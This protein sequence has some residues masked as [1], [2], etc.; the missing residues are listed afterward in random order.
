MTKEQDK[1]LLQRNRDGKIFNFRPVTFCAVFLVLGV[2]FG[3][4]I[5]VKGESPFWALFFLPLS[6]LF[7]FLSTPFM[8]GVKWIGILC[9]FAT[10]G[11]FSFQGVLSRYVDKTDYDGTYTVSGVV[12]EKGGRQDGFTVVLE[13]LSIAGT[14]EKG[15]MVA[16]LPAAF[17]EEIKLSHEIVLYGYVQ[18]DVKLEGEYGFRGGDIAEDIAYRIFSVQSVQSIG[19]TFRPTLWIRQRLSD[20]L[21]AGMDSSVASFCA[22]LLLGDDTRMG[23]TLLTNVRNGGV[24]HLFAV[25]GLHIGVLFGVCAWITSKKFFL[26]KPKIYSFL[27]TALILLFY[28]G[29]CGYSSSVLRA[30][31]TCLSVYAYTLL[32]VKRDVLEG[33]SFAAL[34][35]L[36]LFPTTLFDAGFLLSFSAC[37]GIVLLSRPLK[38]ALNTV[39]DKVSS[40]WRK[41]VLKQEQAV[42]KQDMF[43]GDTPPKSIPTRYKEKVINFLSVTLSAWLATTPVSLAFFGYMSAWGLL[44]NC[45]FVPL[46][47]AFFVALLIVGVLAALLPLVCAGVVLYPLNATFSLVVLFFE[48]CYFGQTAL[49]LSAGTVVCY[50]LA[51]LFCTDK[52]SLS[53]GWKRLAVAT[54]SMACFGCLLAV[55]FL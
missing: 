21:Y 47:S 17:E 41:K 39:C 37:Y 7:V 23:R 9:L 24:A 18:T 4:L 25:S 32:G 42:Q 5:F 28:G 49:L 34:L 6:F 15:K 22:G 53:T 50:Y 43:K 26:R 16:Y 12:V 44:L 51:L 31:V 46:L 30:V 36:L 20:A 48:I 45:I 35:L 3:Y 38:K 52:F 55:N 13:D 27:F 40:V 2:L 10:V 14:P 29:V 54:A 1:L 8:R 19:S 11:V 33:L